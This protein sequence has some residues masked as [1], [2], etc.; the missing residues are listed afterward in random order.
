MAAVLYEAVHLM[1]QQLPAHADT[2]AQAR[3]WKRWWNTSAGKGTVEGY[4]EAWERAGADAIV[5]E[6]N[7]GNG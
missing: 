7:D 3:Y 1:R 4:L 6:T 2:E 5:R